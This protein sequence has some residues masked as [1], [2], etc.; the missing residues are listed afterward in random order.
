MANPL[1][2]QEIVTTQEIAISTVLEIEAP[3]ELLMGRPII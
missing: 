2:N 3:I 1:H